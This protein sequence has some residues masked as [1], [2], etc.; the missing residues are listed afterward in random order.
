MGSLKTNNQNRL[1]HWTAIQNL[2]PTCPKRSLSTEQHQWRQFIRLHA[3]PSGAAKGFIPLLS[4]MQSH[5][6]RPVRTL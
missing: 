5:S 4:H 3:A 2:V 1:D 6:P